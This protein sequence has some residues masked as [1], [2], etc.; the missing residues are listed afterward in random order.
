MKRF[1]D[2]DTNIWFACTTAYRCVKFSLQKCQEFLRS[3]PLS[4]DKDIDKQV[5]VHV[6][7][8]PLLG[9]RPCT[10]TTFHGATVH[11]AA[12]MQIYGILIPGKRPC[13]PKSQV[14]FKPPWALTRDTTVGLPE[15]GWGLIVEYV[16]IYIYL[17][18]HVHVD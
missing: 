1:L 12:S 16:Y 10:C 5:H 18:M 15:Q 17:Y 7:K 14:M 4:S 11:V 3:R 13:G 9:K 6:H 2:R 8:R